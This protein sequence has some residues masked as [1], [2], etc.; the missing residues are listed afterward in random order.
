MESFFILVTKHLILDT[1]FPDQNKLSLSIE[2]K[3][4]SDSLLIK[5]K[6][7]NANFNESYSAMSVFWTGLFVDY[8]P[9]KPNGTKV[10]LKLKI[11]LL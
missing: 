11:E 6:E 8:S 3:K 9:G 2:P 10:W 1:G 4:F 5:A 7:I